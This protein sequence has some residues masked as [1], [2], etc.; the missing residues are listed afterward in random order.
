MNQIRFILNF[1]LLFCFQL[2]QPI[3]Q[4]GGIVPDIGGIAQEMYDQYIEG[5]LKELGSA[6]TG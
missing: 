2:A 3:G 6:I 5:A 4:T 1:G